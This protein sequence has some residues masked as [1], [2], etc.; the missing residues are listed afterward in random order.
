[1]RWRARK[2]AGRAA[3]SLFSAMARSRCSSISASRRSTP[4]WMLPTIFT[5]FSAG[6]EASVLLNSFSPMAVF[7]RSWK[8]V[9]SSTRRRFSWLM[10]VAARTVK[11]APSSS[12]GVART[13]SSRAS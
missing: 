3:S 2:R 13:S 4:E 1:M 11:R 8:K 7:I 12:S 6:A 10:S 9:R 5:A